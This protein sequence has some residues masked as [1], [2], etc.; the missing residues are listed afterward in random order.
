MRKIYADEYTKF[1]D[2]IHKNNTRN[3]AMGFT[4]SPG[5]LISF[6]EFG[7]QFKGGKEGKR[8]R[9]ARNSQLSPSPEPPIYASIHGML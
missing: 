2:E 9:A 4:S 5:A 3:T 8:L 6:R 7:P 1:Y